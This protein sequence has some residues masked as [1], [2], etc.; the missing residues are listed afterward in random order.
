[1]ALKNTQWDLYSKFNLIFTTKQF[2]ILKW[3]KTTR[4][5]VYPVHGAEFSKKPG[6]GF[7]Q[8]CLIPGKFLS[9]VHRNQDFFPLKNKKIKSGLP[10]P[11]SCLRKCL[12]QA[13]IG[14]FEP[15]L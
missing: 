11:K 1:M 6:V 3:G 5:S 14:N 7:S 2:L 15:P 9:Q 4:I 10:K 8:F 12:Y 13:N